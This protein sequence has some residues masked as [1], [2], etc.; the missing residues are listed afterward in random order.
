MAEQTSRLAV[1]ID[2]SGA[3]KNT[4]T[5]ASSLAK[6]TQAGQKAADGAGK[7]TKATQDESHAL[8][9]LLD[10]IDPVNAA[11]NKLDQQQQQLAKFKAK[12]FLDTDTFDAYSKKIDDARSRLGQMS[13]QL[14]KTGQ[15]SKQAAWAMRMIPAQMTD[16]VVGLST[17]Q[18]PFMVLMQ[19]GGQL[20]DMFGG[21]GPAIRGVGG[22]VMGLASPFTIAAGAVAAY[23]LAFHQAQEEMDA[24]NKSA[25]TL[26]NVSGLNLT[27]ITALAHSA[28]ALG[29]SYGDAISAVGSLT[30]SL[31][32]NADMYP[33]II[34][35][36]SDYANASGQDLNSVV[37]MF[38]QLSDSSGKSI[39]QLDDKLGFLTAAQRKQIDAAL[40]GG[41]TADA[42][43]QAFSALSDK[44]GELTTKLNQGATGW[45]NF[46]HSLGSGA[47]NSWEVFKEI[48]G[49]DYL[50]NADIRKYQQRTQQRSN[51][52]SSG[53]WTSDNEQHYQMLNDTPIIKAYVSQLSNLGDAQ[54]KL[55]EQSYL[56]QLNT[57]LSN[58]ADAITK[59][60][61]ALAKLDSQFKQQPK[62]IQEQG[63]SDYLALRAKYSQNLA[64]A[65]SAA[66]KKDKAPA[67]KAYSEDAG[68]K[69]IDQ[70]NQQHA[71][72]VAQVDATQKL[73]SAQQELV[74]WQTKLDGL[75]KKKNLTADDK[76]LL[77]NQNK[78]TSLYKANALEEQT[79]QAK[80]EAKKIFDYQTQLD[81]QL[82]TARNANSAK[83][84][85]LGMG[86]LEAGRIKYLQDLQNKQDSDS[87]A[88]LDKRDRG[89]LTESGYQSELASLKSY[90][91]QRAQ[92]AHDGFSL[93]NSYRQDWQKGFMSGLQNSIDA[94]SDMYSQ[95]ASLAQTTYDGMAS[96]LAN[97]VVTGKAN[98]KDFTRSVIADLAQIEAKRALAGLATSLLGGVSS[99]FSPSVAGNAGTA[100]SGNGALGLSTSFADYATKNAKGGVYDSP[101]LSA[102][103]NQVYS[104][105]KLFAFAKGAGVFG[106]AGPEAIMP[107]TR[108]KNGSLG[109][110]AIG[111]QSST[112]GDINLGGIVVNV[113][114]NGKASSGSSTDGQGIGK[115]IQSAVI[116]TINEQA[117][118]QGTPLWRA[119]KGR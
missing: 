6:L 114:S 58:N 28:S 40:E 81:Q 34:K 5:L 90:Y 102:Y 26:N 27:Q 74:K 99:L 64:D 36:S 66:A 55:Q 112:G 118:K 119:I 53:T 19:Q 109:V 15:S 23:G 44:L 39:D 62:N 30:Q 89:D 11:L 60:R 100:L 43:R 3:Q 21:I 42:Q 80:A 37:G 111:D 50:D 97:F 107:L 76:S 4:E 83:F 86:D 71:A 45:N 20:K 63:R 8:S 2:S 115:Q 46:W 113:D 1:I 104:S 96:S 101:S 61:E 77:A 38:S 13:E 78:I 73:G 51:A 94:S 103:S 52:M 116:N 82:Q 93:E 106:E 24:L 117:T 7:V 29:V 75:T 10:R 87:Q 48:A 59:A 72:L 49:G 25:N 79:Q 68:T 47:S 84:A 31:S 110:R 32:T 105:P 98:F 67:T 18:S 65:E 91:Q 108:G 69:L 12:G 95:M 35:A 9:Q 70:L 17:G 92:I 54:K 33:Q 41:N 14:V 85:G 88:L 57:D 56:K 16:I 22:Y